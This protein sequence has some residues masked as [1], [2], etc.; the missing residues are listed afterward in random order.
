MTFGSPL[1]AQMGLLALVYAFSAAGAALIAVQASAV[2][3]AGTL[4]CYFYIFSG[5]PCAIT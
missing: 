1:L 4:V 3:L 2:S 5:L